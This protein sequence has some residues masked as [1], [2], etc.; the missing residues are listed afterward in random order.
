MAMY[1]F[2]GGLRSLEQVERPCLWEFTGWS[3]VL[4]LSVHPKCLG[5]RCSVS[6]PERIAVALDV[7]DGL[8]RTSGWLEDSG[9]AP[10]TWRASWLIGA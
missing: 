1:Q 2:G 6:T 8:V 3:W 5:R 7:R 10:L 9:I 4:P